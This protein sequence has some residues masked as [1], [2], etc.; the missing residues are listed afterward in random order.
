MWEINSKRTQSYA[1]RT[2]NPN[3]LPCLWD[4]I[5]CSDWP[6]TIYFVLNLA[7]M[8]R[9]VT[10]DRN[11]GLPADWNGSTKRGRVA[12][13]RWKS[14]R[15]APQNNEMNSVH[16][17]TPS[18]RWHSDQLRWAS[19]VLVFHEVSSQSAIVHFQ[20]RFFLWF[21]FFVCLLFGLF[22]FISFCFAAAIFDRQPCVDSLTIPYNI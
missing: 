9:K 7:R 3:S 10:R 16:N 13:V 5:Y 2:Y 19:H 21:F 11:Y 20:S 1:W 12:V 17:E 14:D 22:R 18:D 4:S 6:I 15:E 8:N